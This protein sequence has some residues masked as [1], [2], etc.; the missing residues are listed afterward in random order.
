MNGRFIKKLKIQRT[1]AF[2]ARKLDKER[3]EK[4]GQHRQRQ[5]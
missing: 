5:I 3:K 2:V 4:G 1:L